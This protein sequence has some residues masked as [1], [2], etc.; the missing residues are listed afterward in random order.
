MS[1][2]LEQLAALHEAA[3]VKTPAPWDYAG[4]GWVRHGDPAVGSD[5]FPEVLAANAS[6]D[7][8][9]AFIAEA[10][11]ALPELLE[12]LE[13]AETGTLLY[14]CCA[15]CPDDDPEYHAENPPNIHTT[16]CTH[17]G[18]PIWIARA[19]A[20]EARGVE[21]EAGI[22]ALAEVEPNVP[23]ASKNYEDGYR[24]GFKMAQQKIRALLNGT[25]KDTE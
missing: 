25:D 7:E 19:D 14:A 5:Q 2:D 10:F 23:K 18:P 13:A 1:I 15:C 20:A 4:Q 9:G 17:C 6:T 3:T 8:A 16:W 22:K 24:V 21:L 11:N 12:R